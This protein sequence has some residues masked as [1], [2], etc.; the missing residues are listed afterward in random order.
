MRTITKLAHLG[1][2]GPRAPFAGVF[3]HVK[4]ALSAAVE[5]RPLRPLQDIDEWSHHSEVAFYEDGRPGR[6]V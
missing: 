6:A 3:D 1:T 5:R 2:A 4:R